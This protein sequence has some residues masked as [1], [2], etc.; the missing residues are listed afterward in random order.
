[1]RKTKERTRTAAVLPRQSV[2]DPFHPSKSVVLSADIT[3]NQET[4]SHHRWGVSGERR[5]ELGRPCVRPVVL[6]GA[7]WTKGK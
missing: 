5:E 3:K 6:G 7:K 2:P 1:M 4:R